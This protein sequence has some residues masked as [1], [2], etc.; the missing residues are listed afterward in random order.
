M[1][2]SSLDSEQLLGQGWRSLSLTFR[3]PA[4]PGQVPGQVQSQSSIHVCC[5]TD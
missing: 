1:C 2:S 5:T 3:P 4:A